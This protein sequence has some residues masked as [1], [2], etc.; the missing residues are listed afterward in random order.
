MDAAASHVLLFGDQT[1]EKLPGVRVLAQ[2]ANT[3]PV[4]SRFLRAAAD[5][6]QTELRHLPADAQAD[7]DDFDTIL[8]LAEA[9]AT[10]AEPNETIATALMAVTR[11]GELIM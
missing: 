8:G 7:V 10:R 6:I 4:A 2:Q 5:A 9:N 1:V 3:C 11:L